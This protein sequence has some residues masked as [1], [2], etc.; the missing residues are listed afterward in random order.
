M[1]SYAYIDELKSQ[2][3]K[4][5]NTVAALASQSRDERAKY[6]ESLKILRDRLSEIAYAEK[7]GKEEGKAEGK[8]EGKAEMARNLKAMGF[9]IEAIAKASG[10]SIEEIEQL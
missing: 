8:E 6:D 7:R 2:L 9:P 1:E 5:L 4:K 10:L 3:I